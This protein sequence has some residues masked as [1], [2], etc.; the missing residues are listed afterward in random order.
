MRYRE[1]VIGCT[2]NGIL[3]ATRGEISSGPAMGTW[4]NG[5]RT[6]LKT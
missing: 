5:R 4:R 1:R 6:T 2:E 3:V